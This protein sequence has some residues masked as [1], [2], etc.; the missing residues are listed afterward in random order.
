M[1]SAET[2]CEK[3]AARDEMRAKET[4][5]RQLNKLGGTPFRLDTLQLQ[6]ETLPFL[7]ASLLNELRRQAVEQLQQE[8]IAHFRPKDKVHIPNEIPYFESL[9]DYRANVINK[10]AEA[11]Y[12][13]HQAVCSEYGLEATQEYQ[14]KALMTTKYCLRYEL[15]QC[16]M[17]KCNKTVAPDYQG[18]LYLQNNGN[19]FPLRFDCPACKMQVLAPEITT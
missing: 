12:R 3:T 7:P 11:F 4:I 17:H 16:L 9:L 15:G 1:A 8:R 2:D 5:E 10:K 18:T 13:H 19:R 6:M 14:D